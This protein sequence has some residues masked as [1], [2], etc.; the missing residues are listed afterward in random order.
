MQ[1]N[2]SAVHHFLRFKSPF[3][4]A[5]GV[6]EGTN[7]VIVKA[8]CEGKVGFG[9]ASLPPY[10]PAT[11]ESTLNC[12]NQPILRQI[13]FP[14]E[15]AKIM[16]QLDFNVS[17]EMPGKAAIEMALWNLKS[18]LENK[19]LNEIWKIE[20]KP[21][22]IPH[23]YTI[24]IGNKHEMETKISEAMSVGFDHF[25]LKLNGENDFE[26][27]KNFKSI[28][29]AT[30]AVDVNQGWNSL[31]HANKVAEVLQE[32][33]CILIE[34]PFDK[35]DRSMSRELRNNFEIPIIADEACQVLPD[36][37]GLFNSFDGINIKIQKCGGI[38][39]ALEMIKL[40]RPEGQKIL[41]GCMSESSIG[42][43][44]AE[45]L[46]PLCDWADLDGPFLTVD[47]L[48]PSTLFEI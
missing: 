19:P 17:G 11:V 13:F 8:E 29:N 24:G 14:F 48:N 12:L 26:T 40:A 39:N 41:I 1:I 35:T 38:V 27:I 25:K 32:S 36:L 44:I 4:I 33:K 21:N 30:F 47:I 22:L 45:Q 9:E 31:D 2:I 3:R 5:H 43:G 46:T 28:S 20:Q 16:A 34:Q 23:F 15:I 7:V 42:C 10:L 18:V 6:R 37:P